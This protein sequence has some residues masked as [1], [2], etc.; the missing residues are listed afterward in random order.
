MA[1]LYDLQHEKQEK[2]LYTS[3]TTGS[4][5]G[6]TFMIPKTDDDLIARREAIMEWQTFTGGLM[7]R[8]HD[9]LNAS[10][11]AMGEADVF[12]TVGDLTFA[13]RNNN[14]YE[15]ERK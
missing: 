15:Y 12:F 14:S 5:V 2:M 4:K 7:E 8:S 11:V 3:P 13:E 10:D 9:Y 1:K 6:K